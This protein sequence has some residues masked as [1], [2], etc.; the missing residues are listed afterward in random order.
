MNKTDTLLILT[1]L[2]ALTGMTANIMLRSS[3]IEKH[4]EKIVFM[5]EEA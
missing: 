4:L 5:L 2:A 1:L 3:L